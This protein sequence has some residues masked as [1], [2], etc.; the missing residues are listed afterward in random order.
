MRIVHGADEVPID[1]GVLECEVRPNCQTPPFE[2]TSTFSWLTVGDRGVR[3][4]SAA[5][6]TVLAFTNNLDRHN[7][8]RKYITQT[9]NKV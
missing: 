5:V 3:L 7:E 4:A 9:L 1:K 2:G 8:Y 6:A